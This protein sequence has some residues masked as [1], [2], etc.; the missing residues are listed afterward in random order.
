MQHITLK[1]FILFIAGVL[2]LNTYAHSSQ[3]DL[4]AELQNYIKIFQS[5]STSAQR[6]AITELN[7]S[8]ITDTRLY[9][10]IETRLLNQYKTN[11]TRAGLDHSAWLAKTL[12]YSGNPKYQKTFDLILNDDSDKKLRKIQKHTKKAQ[13]NLPKFTA[14]NKQISKGLARAPQGRLKQQRVLNMLNSND[15][16]LVRVGAKRVNFEYYDDQ[17]LIDAAEN[18][19]LSE[20]KKDGDKIFVDSMAWLCKAL[21]STGNV[22]Y[23]ATLTEVMENATH[24]RV[25]KQAKKYIRYL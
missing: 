8:G 20:Y 23:R 24:R 18:K 6:T 19:L 11:T 13:K 2:F 17:E 22:K 4:E 12:S 14:W 10:T 9:D 16:A 3:T 25:A 15:Y 7:W 21:S 5:N 1:K